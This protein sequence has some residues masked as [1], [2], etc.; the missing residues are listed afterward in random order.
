M[1]LSFAPYLSE[2]LGTALLTYAFNCGGQS[3]AIRGYAYFLSFLLAFRFSGAH[4]NPALTLAKYF[5]AKS[6]AKN[7]KSFVKR[8]LLIWVA[9]I[10]GS[11][12]GIFMVYILIKDKGNYRLLPKNL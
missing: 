3:F 12:F 6:E 9:Q 10:L 11:F 4:F 5:S 2:F 1:K 7:C 8:V